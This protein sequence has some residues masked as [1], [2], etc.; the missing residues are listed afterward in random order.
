MI[1]LWRSGAWPFFW[2]IMTT[3]NVN[4]HA[5]SRTA[6]A[7]YRVEFLLL[8][9]PP[10]GLVHLAAVPLAI[11]VLARLLAPAARAGTARPLPVY[12]GHLLLAVFY[13][14]WL[15]QTTFLQM[16]HDYV[17]VPS[18]LLAVAV[19]ASSGGSLWRTRVGKVN[20]L[21][22]FAVAFVLHPFAYPRRLAL[23][24]RCMTEGSSPEV[25]NRLSHIN[26]VD[27]P[28]WVQLAAVADF[29]RGQD[30]HDGELLCYDPTSCPLYLMLDVSPPSRAVHFRMIWLYP[31]GVPQ[32]IDQLNAHPLRFAVTDL[33]YS[34]LPEAEFQSNTADA[35]LRLPLSFPAEQGSYFPWSEPI[36]FRSG[37][38]LVHRVTGP[39][40]ELYNPWV[41]K[42]PTGSKVLPGQQPP[43]RAG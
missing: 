4:Y 39:V 8:R 11:A 34:R 28:D 37:R 27:N 40:K 10:W 33:R 30:L 5:V 12:A 22:F 2:E 31:P 14:G 32:L 9:L 21:V 6:G 18:A 20:L 1:W 25:R 41:T 26:S 16:P 36:V 38:Y 17:L 19:V 3:V 23:W 15:A 35:S 7:G 29:L 43:G 24:P 42:E 13:L